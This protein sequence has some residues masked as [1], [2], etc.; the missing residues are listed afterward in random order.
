LTEFT[1][2]RVIPGLVEQNLWNEHISRYSFATGLAT[3]KRVLDVG[4]G[5][6]YGTASMAATAELALGFDISPEA[7]D[8]A[9]HNYGGKA[10]FVVGS[11]ES[12]PVAA[13]SF[14][15]ITAF[16]VIE[17]L[18][19]WQRLLSEASRALAEDGLFLVSTP[20]KT[21]YGEARQRM[22]PNAFHVHEFEHA[23]FVE[24]LTTWFP[25]VRILAQNRVEAF[26]L[27]GE[28]SPVTGV[29]AFAGV[30]DDVSTAHFYV[31]VCGRRPIPALAYVYVPHEGNLLW[32]RERHIRLLEQQLEALKWERER[33]IRLLEQQLEALNAA[34]TTWIAAL[35]QQLL[36]HQAERDAALAALTTAEH[37]LKER[38]N[39]ALKLDRELASAHGDMNALIAKLGDAEAVVIE[40]T[41]WAL[42]LDQELT[43]A[44]TRVTELTATVGERE[45]V[46]S[47]LTGEVTRGRSELGVLLGALR[48][49]SAAAEEHG[50]SMQSPGLPHDQFAQLRELVV[51]LEKLRVSHARLFEIQME[52]RS[53]LQRRVEALFQERKLAAGS[54]WLRLGRA[55]GVGPKLEE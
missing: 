15:L 10:K 37:E 26:S 47:E 8:H 43:Q 35:E 46:I 32:E 34:R 41:N 51:E 4:C 5:T 52:S 29:A 31:A 25:N 18:A 21:Y 30:C 28:Q 49:Q 39:W 36:D 33:H 6:G 38:T 44:Q 55:L 7:I 3:K 50:H 2:E 23:E 12:F 20:N 27:F 48:D 1:G 22:G 16:E 13:E 14:D 45:A 54:R 42:K 53:A 11:A 9:I 19:G 40:R 17:H 24:A